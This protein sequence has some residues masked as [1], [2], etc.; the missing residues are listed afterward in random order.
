VN[1]YV[2]AEKERNH[3]KKRGLKTSKLERK[4]GVLLAIYY[5]TNYPT[6]VNLAHVFENRSSYCHKIYSCYAII[7][8]KVEA[9]PL[10]K[11]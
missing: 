10:S 4:D 5:L 8:A 7:L 1:V 3:L 2:D 6:F 11:N 9:L